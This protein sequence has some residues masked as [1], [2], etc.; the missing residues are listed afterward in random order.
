[1]V[2]LSG[3]VAE[4]EALEPAHQEQRARG[5]CQHADAIRGHVRR[6]AGSLLALGQAFDPERIDDD[7]LCGGRRGHQQRAQCDQPWRLGRIADGK[8]DDRRDQE[9]LRKNQPAAAATQECGEHRY[10]E[11]IDDRCPEELDRVRRADQREQADSAEIDARLAHP[12]QQGRARER[13][14]QSGGEAE[15]Q[16]DEHA[17]LQIDRERVGKARA[18]RRGFGR[19]GHR[20]SYR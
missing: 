12:D 10:V 7:V 2:D 1:V 19:D 18:G 20:L 13:E 8:K 11:G 9:E 3:S 14:R 6:H 5:R 16:Y 15:E 17:R 4:P